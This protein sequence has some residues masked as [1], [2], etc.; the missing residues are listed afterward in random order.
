[1]CFNI[2]QIFLKHQYIMT[3]ELSKL[4]PNILSYDPLI[5]VLNNFLTRRM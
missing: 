5:Y 2:L 3:Q 4:L 1:M